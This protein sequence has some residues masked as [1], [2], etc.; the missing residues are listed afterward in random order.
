MNKPVRV[1]QPLWA[2][3]R[4]S[5]LVRCVC[6]EM[7][8]LSLTKASLNNEEAFGFAQ[9]DYRRVDGGWERD[10]ECDKCGTTLRVPH[11]PSFPEARNDFPHDLDRGPGV[12]HVVRRFEIG[13]RR[14]PHI[15]TRFYSGVYVQLSKKG[16]LTAKVRH[17]ALGVTITPQKHFYSVGATEELAVLNEKG[18]LYSVT[19]NNRVGDQTYTLTNGLRVHSAVL[20]C[21]PREYVRDNMLSALSEHLEMDVSEVEEEFPPG[22][23]IKEM[24][25]KVRRIKV[26]RQYGM[27]TDE[28]DGIDLTRLIPFGPH[29]RRDTFVRLTQLHK[30]RNYQDAVITAI[31]R[32]KSPYSRKELMKNLDVV[33]ESPWVIWAVD[34]TIRTLRAMKIDHGRTQRIVDRVIIDAL[35]VRNEPDLQVR[36]A[37]DEMSRRLS[38]IMRLRTDLFP[39]PQTVAAA[40]RLNYQTL[41]PVI[42]DRIKGI[43]AEDFVQWACDDI[44][45][46]CR[47]ITIWLDTLNMMNARRTPQE[48]EEHFLRLWEEHNHNIMVVHDALIAERNLQY[49]RRTAQQQAEWELQ[50]QKER[51]E[52]AEYKTP[53]DQMRRFNR[54]LAHMTF[55]VQHPKDFEKLGRDM[56]NCVSGYTRQVVY[57][58]GMIV[59]AYEVDNKKPLVCIEVEL[60][61]N[62]LR[63]AKEV[64]NVP[65]GRNYSLNTAVHAWMQEVNLQSGGYDLVEPDPELIPLYTNDVE[66]IPIPNEE[67]TADDI[68]EEGHAN[69]VLE[70]VRQIVRHRDEFV[71]FDFPF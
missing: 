50:R 6:G 16:N 54:R 40:R 71:D 45:Q 35:G 32:L 27:T 29:R 65:V 38:S 41:Y 62:R 34:E 20:S 9:L 18:V 11:T 43:A 5:R 59:A 68:V 49:T 44:T 33:L 13:N 55:L 60:D 7:H 26:C 67:D 36:D 23:D 56:H 25:S 15:G 66:K 14:Y 61:T 63:Q 28:L 17:T 53:K 70:E 30:Y 57:H 37:M 47:N 3:R 4:D 1:F 48:I 39:P 51:K 64:C 10:M 46:A 12:S 24:F 52:L 42:T 22:T 8:V 58:K 21:V 31:S 2:L 69:K 19:G